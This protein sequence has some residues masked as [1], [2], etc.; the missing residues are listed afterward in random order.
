MKTEVKRRNGWK[1][2]G[3]IS[4]VVAI[5]MTSACSVLFFHGGYHVRLL[6][7][8]GLREPEAKVNYAVIA[9]ENCLVQMNYD[10]DIAFLGDSITRGGD[11]G[12]YFSDYKIANLGYS[13]DSLEGMYDRTGMVTA[14]KPEKIFLMG[15]INGLKDGNVS[16]SY[17]SY[18]RL[19][20]CLQEEL[21]EAQIYIQ[22]VLPIARER[23]R[24]VCENTTIVELNQKLKQL[25]EKTGV[26]YIDLHELYVLNGELNP[27][28]GK[29]GIHLKK[30]SYILWYEAIEQYAEN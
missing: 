25:A 22:S 14:V 17:A 5:L 12:Q 10:A 7:R 20:H 8:M 30:E 26:V 13:G 23:E 4:I 28:Y 1:T 21:P 9:W 29:D 16:Q 15:G 3:I 19:V 24:T 6:Q 2:M 11:F 27:N 18:E